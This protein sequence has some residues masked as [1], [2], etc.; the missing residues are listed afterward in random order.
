[1]SVSLTHDPPSDQ[2]ALSFWIDTVLEGGDGIIAA[3]LTQSADQSP[4]VVGTT[5]HDGAGSATQGRRERLRHCHIVSPVTN[6]DSRAE[7]WTL[8]T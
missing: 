8:R 4:S 5:A 6:A 7:T 1:M 2:R 3:D